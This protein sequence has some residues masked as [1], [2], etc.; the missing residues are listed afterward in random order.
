MPIVIVDTVGTLIY[1][2]EP[3]E[4][5]LAQRFEE[6]GEMAASVWSAEFAVDDENRQP[7]PHEEWPLVIALTEQRP[8]FRLIWLKS[9]DGQWRHINWT[10]VPFIAQGGEFLGVQSIFWEVG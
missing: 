7:I 8:I 9:P 6:T 4:A 2:N 5:L 10:S 3:A 1:Y